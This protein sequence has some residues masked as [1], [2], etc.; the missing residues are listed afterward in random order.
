[1]IRRTFC[2]TVPGKYRQ[3]DLFIKKMY[4]ILISSAMSCLSESKLV[5]LKFLISVA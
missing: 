1:M 2:W 5:S 3:L 4:G